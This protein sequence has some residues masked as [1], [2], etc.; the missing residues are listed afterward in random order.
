M[1]AR[2]FAIAVAAFAACSGPSLAQ[3]ARHCAFAEVARDRI[4]AGLL[5]AE[6]S[7]LSGE[8]AYFA[9]ALG[10]SPSAADAFGRRISE[11][12]NEGRKLRSESR[13]DLARSGVVEGV[14]AG[15]ERVIARNA[16]FDA[17][18]LAHDYLLA[19]RCAR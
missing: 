6:P 5:D 1:R 12:R 17:W 10:L 4:A 18:S 9:G 16:E 2:M 14:V 3:S 19:S 11:I 8:I 13:Q 15:I 7:A